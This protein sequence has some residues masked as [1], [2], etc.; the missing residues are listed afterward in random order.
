MILE[1]LIQEYGE[2]AVLAKLEELDEGI[3]INR[4]DYNTFEIK[5]KEEQ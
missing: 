2:C 1:Q 4:I 5:P 3:V